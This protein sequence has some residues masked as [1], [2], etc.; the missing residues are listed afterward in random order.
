MRILLFVGALTVAASFVA[1]QDGG[2]AGGGGGAAVPGDAEGAADDFADMFDDDIGI[3]VVASPET[4]QVMH[5]I[6]R[7]AIVASNAPDVITLLRET[8]GVS[9]TSY[10]GHG[11]KES[12][13][14]RGFD[15]D[16][17]AILIDGVPVNA[18]DTGDFDLGTIDPDSIEAIEVISGGSDTKYN[19]SGALGGVVNIITVKKQAPGVTVHG[20]VSTMAALPGTSVPRGGDD[21]SP[22][23]ED[24]VD[25]QKASVTVAYGA[26]VFSLTATA[27]ATRAGNHFLYE[28]YTGDTY[29]KVNNE[30]YDGG[31]ALG[32][33]RTLANSGTFIAKADAYYGK[34]KVPTSGYAIA[35]ENETDVT[36]R[37]SLFFDLP[38][39]TDAAAVEASVTHDWKRTDYAESSHNLHSVTAINRWAFFTTDALTLRIGF[40]ARAV[41]LDSTDEGERERID[42]GIFAT[43]EIAVGRDVL[44]VPSVKVV[45]TTAGERALVPVPKFG[46]LWNAADHVIVKA[47]VYRSF[48]YP[49]FEDLYWNSGGMTGNP[50][51]K[52]EDGW[53]GDGGVAWSDG[54]TSVTGTA[55]YQWTADSIHWA[56]TNGEWHPD[57]VGKAAYFGI[58][59]GAA[60]KKNVAAGPF[61]AVTLG[62][63]YQYL[64]STLLS[65]GY[66]AK[67]KKRIPY[68]SPHV[69]TGTAKVAWSAPRGPGSAAVILRYEGLRYSD[70]ANYLPLDP[71]TVVTVNATQ[72]ITATLAAYAVIRNAFNTTYTT[73][74][75]Y[76]LPGTTVTVGVRF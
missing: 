23:F 24:L 48:K 18:P 42:G 57:N 14:L 33:V 36:S 6:D 70:T 64:H 65:Y 38:A 53:G 8:L 35:F 2:A 41:A 59:L 40:D 10:G 54:A 30:V 61:T 68:M 9:V 17:V 58:D 1:A 25:T 19:V 62:A 44:L 50:D 47:N 71:Y 46:A 12:V 34:K 27:F 73:V 7:D 20:T 67:D 13:S 76:P 49:D 26:P 37:Q 74:A 75:D 72:N 4:T 63:D 56:V 32:F 29:R 52:S 11:A 3:T 21:G 15:S 45:G 31:A 43:G 60:T 66:T 39:V 55:F 69:F 51:L 16:R 5:V 28:H 22:H